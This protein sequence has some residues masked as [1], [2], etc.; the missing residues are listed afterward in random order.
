M[1]IDV[2]AH[3]VDRAYLDE[4]S[5]LMGLTGSMTP[6]GQTLL[7]KGGTTVAWYR[8]SFFD[9][10]LRVRQMDEAGV[11]IR[12]VSVSSPSIYEWSASEQPRIARRSN[13]CLARYCAAYP[14]RFKGL[15]VLPLADADA[16]MEE[17]RYALDELG[18]RGIAIGT[19]VGGR[20]LNHPDLERVWA[21][22]DSRRV[23]VV[24]HPMQPLGADHLDQFELPIRVGFVYETTTALSRMIYGGI[25]ERYP[26]FPF[27]VPHTGGAL[28]TLLERLDN[29][30]RLFPDC[31]KNISKM[32]SEYA[33]GLF[34]DTCSF[35]GPA[36]MMAHGILGPQQLLWGTDDPFIGA[37]TSHVDKLDVSAWDKALILGGNAARI[38]GIDAV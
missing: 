31:R 8:E 30:Y 4:L 6:D 10:D 2:H 15:A 21:L 19:H 5:S 25:F 26:N 17:L 12:L 32:P 23:P 37:D 16:A 24:Q 38:F 14:S 22:I 35:Y 33:H 13:E 36:L 18:M 7:R 27:V 20:P 29:G 34:Y 11:D 28:L 9:Q 3:I 1:K